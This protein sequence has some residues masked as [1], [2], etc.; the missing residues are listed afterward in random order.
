MKTINCL[1]LYFF[2]LLS[3][4]LHAQELN[5]FYLDLIDKKNSENIGFISLSEIYRYDVNPSLHDSLAMPDHKEINDFHYIRLDSAYR[6]RFLL[7]TDVSETDKVFIYDYATDLLKTFKVKDLKVAAILNNY[8]SPE[9]CPC[10]QYYYM[11]GLEIDGK[12][13]E[14]FKKHFNNTVVYIGKKNP[15]VRRQ[16]KPMIWEKSESIDFPYPASKSDSVK[17]SFGFGVCTIGNT[18]TLESEGFQYFVQ[19]FIEGYGDVIARLLVVIHS[20]TKEIVCEKFYSDSEGTGLAPL[21]LFNSESTFGAEQ[22]TGKLFE[23]K[24]PV[25]FGFE[26]HSFG[27]PAISFLDK[28]ETDI[29][30]KCDNRH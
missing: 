25:V 8:T 3:P 1:I 23:N 12:L 20:E 2:L 11:M 7:R 10:P 24:P 18:Y 19:D 15:F 21:Q 29:Y 26:Y 4:A 22:W 9:E 16:L 14:G 17:H 27:C 28:S 13:L 6:E 5:L 30:I